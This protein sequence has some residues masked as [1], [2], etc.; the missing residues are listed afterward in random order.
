V[1]KDALLAQLKDIHLPKPIGFWPLAYGWYVL[2]VL[3]FV[4]LLALVLGLRQHRRN[5]RPKKEAL[6]LLANYQEQ[7]EQKHHTTL[8][9][10]QISQLLKRVA[11][12]YYPRDEVAGL[13]GEAWLSFLNQEAVDLDFKPLEDLPYKPESSVDLQPLFKSARRWIQ[14]RKAPCSN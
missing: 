4:L 11:L 2:A 13:H 10:A 3:V 6:H 14:Q 12:A 8:A 5:A 7:Y 9:C 1:D